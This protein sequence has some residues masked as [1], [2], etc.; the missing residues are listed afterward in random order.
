MTET[1][2]PKGFESL[3]CHAPEWVLPDQLARQRKRAASDLAAIQFVL[4]NLITLCALA[5][6][7]P[8]VSRTMSRSGYRACLGARY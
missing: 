3:A 2:F 5:A 8:G 1:M 7:Y 4:S 6:R